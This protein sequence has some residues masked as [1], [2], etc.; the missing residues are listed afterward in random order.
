MPVS[1]DVAPP[2]LVSIGVVIST[3]SLTSVDPVTGLSRAL[4]N[5]V[6]EYSA[7]FQEAV[8]LTPYTIA[9]ESPRNNETVTT[10][11]LLELRFK[12]AAQDGDLLTPWCKLQ[13]AAESGELINSLSTVLPEAEVARWLTGGVSLEGCSWCVCPDAGPVTPGDIGRVPSSSVDAVECFY[14]AK[15]GLIKTCI[16]NDDVTAAGCSCTY[17]GD[18]TAVAEEYLQCWDKPQ[19]D[20]SETA[21]QKSALVPVLIILFL[22]LFGVIAWLCWNK[23]QKD[24]GPGEVTTTSQ[25]TLNPAHTIGADYAAAPP[26]ESAYSDTPA[27]AAFGGAAGGGAT[28][29]MVEDAVATAAVGGFSNPQYERCGALPNATYSTVGAAGGAHITS[30]NPTYD[31]AGIAAVG[32]AGGAHIISANPTYDSAGIAAV[33]AAGGAH[34]ISANPTYD[35]AGSD[36]DLDAL[37]MEADLAGRTTL[38]N[39]TYAMDASEEV[40]C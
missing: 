30:A 25:F 29:A 21:K 35:S 2:P 9:A 31:S 34:I 37:G 12:V 40:E 33:G 5:M 28:Y 4:V 15:H 13:A 16:G 19:K 22:I 17:K 11:E 24:R 26:G 39:S 27:N 14:D 7:L 3:G 10:P 1:V 6:D 18:S 20:C 8:G 23:T 32:A 38:Q 36:L